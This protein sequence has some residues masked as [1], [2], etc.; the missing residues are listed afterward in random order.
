MHPLKRGFEAK[1]SSLFFFLTP[2][3]FISPSP[4]VCLA[5][6]ALGETSRDMTQLKQANLVSPGSSSS[7]WT[8]LCHRQI[9]DC[10]HHFL[11]LFGLFGQVQWEQA[12][13]MDREMMWWGVG[14]GIWQPSARWGL[15]WSHLTSSYWGFSAKNNAPAEVWKSPCQHC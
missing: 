11:L 10:E 14:G 9:S 3:G 13:W 4:S 7:L 2:P 1:H 8:I 12:S 6:Q 15:G 5:R